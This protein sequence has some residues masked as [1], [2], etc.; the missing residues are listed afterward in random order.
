M[1]RVHAEQVSNRTGSIPTKV[2]TKPVDKSKEFAAMEGL[3]VGAGSDTELRHM[4]DG[5]K[6]RLETETEKNGTKGKRIH[7]DPGRYRHGAGRNRTGAETK[8]RQEAPARGHFG[9]CGAEGC[10]A[11]EYGAD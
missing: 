6:E 9:E 8:R 11:A 10:G 1:G 3:G 5:A 7:A 2:F 4:M